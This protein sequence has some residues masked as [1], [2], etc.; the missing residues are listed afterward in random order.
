MKKLVPDGRGSSLNFT[1]KSHLISHKSLG[2]RRAEGEDRLRHGHWG[3]E[4]LSQ[5]LLLPLPGAVNQWLVKYPVLCPLALR[6]AWITLPPKI[7]LGVWPH[8]DGKK[9]NKTKQNEIQGSTE[10][11]LTSYWADSHF[12]GLWDLKPSKQR[13][14][15]LDSE[16]MPLALL[17]GPPL[18][19]LSHCCLNNSKSAYSRR[20]SLV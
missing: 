14:I 2:S 4:K 16:W 20:T 6:T 11:I 12:H 19:V 1:L 7:G 5:Q 15:L 17:P 13:W 9:Q 8:I 3:R 10:T 18:C